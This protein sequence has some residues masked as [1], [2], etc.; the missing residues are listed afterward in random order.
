MSFE[1]FRARFCSKPKA[2]WTK[3]TSVSK[4][5]K[6]FRGSR[7]SSKKRSTTVKMQRR[8][9]GD[10]HQQFSLRMKKTWVIRKLRG[11]SLGISTS[12]ACELKML[13]LTKRQLGRWGQYPLQF[14]RSSKR[15]L[16]RRKSKPKSTMPSNSNQFEQSYRERTYS[17]RT[18]SSKPIVLSRDSQ[19]RLCWSSWRSWIKE[20][21][22]STS[23]RSSNNRAWSRK[24]NLSR[25]RPRKWPSVSQAQ[26]WWSNWRIW[27][28][29]A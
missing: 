21:S 29:G 15:T 23:W 6:S 20:T 19:V 4:S 9:W 8:S 25:N 26:F 17:S 1:D 27:I 18:A 3:K 14:W 2:N 10:C 5:G 22:R 16:I 28:I 7:K 13:G 12:K 24:E 11:K